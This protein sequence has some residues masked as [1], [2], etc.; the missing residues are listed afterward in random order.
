MG[1]ETSRPLV[2][3]RILDTRSGV[4]A[5]ATPVGPGGVV[6]LDVTG[7]GG[8]PEAGVGAV[9][10]NVTAVGATAP[11]FVTVWPR[12][13]VRP[14]ASSLNLVRGETSP[15][16]V[17]AKVGRDGGVEL[18]NNKGTVHLLARRRRVVP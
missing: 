2:P 9:A 6:T 3:S 15:N 18:F 16:L 8:V 14:V 17:V 1:P 5:A 4:G 10:L 11:T 7:R 12:G 13:A